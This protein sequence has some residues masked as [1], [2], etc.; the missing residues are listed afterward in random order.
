MTLLVTGATGFVMSVLG[1]HWLET[2][3]AAR[4]VVLDASPLDATVQRYFGP[5]RERLSVIIADVTH[6]ETW[7][8]AVARHAPLALTQLR[9]RAKV[10]PGEWVLIMGA[11]GRDFHNFNVVYR[12]DPSVEVVAFTATQIPFINDRT[13]PASLAGPRYPDGIRIHDESELSRLIHALHVQDVVF[14]YSDVSHQ[15]VMHKAS[16]AIAAGANFLMNDSGTSKGWI[17]QYTFSSRT[18]RA[19]S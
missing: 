11:A 1:R 14:G 19:M 9:E 5:V 7:Q 4:L 8:P 13:Y 2:D 17:S 15:Y 6:S 18:R 12:D 10:K 16:E 3:P